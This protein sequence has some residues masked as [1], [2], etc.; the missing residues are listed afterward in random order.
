MSSVSLQSCCC[1]TASCQREWP[2]L[3]R[4]L[5]ASTIFWP[6][7]F[8]KPSARYWGTTVVPPYSAALRNWR[9]SLGSLCREE[10]ELPL[11]NRGGDGLNS[12]QY[13]CRFY[14]AYW[15]CCWPLA[16]SG[17]ARFAGECTPSGE[18]AAE[19]LKATACFCRA[20][21]RRPRPAARTAT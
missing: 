17:R 20:R 18:C 13:Y 2:H 8:S 4:N 6:A 11:L 19:C 1:T 21:P 10:G 16:R 14:H 15:C 7:F 5:S 9:A 3:L 12:A